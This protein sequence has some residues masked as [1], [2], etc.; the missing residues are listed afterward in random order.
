RLGGRLERD[1]APIHRRRPGSVGCRGR[2]GQTGAV[3]QGGSV[4]SRSHQSRSPV[5]RP[6]PGRRRPGESTSGGDGGGRVRIP[7]LGSDCF[8]EPIALERKAAASDVRRGALDLPEGWRGEG[9]KLRGSSGPPG[10]SDCPAGIPWTST[11]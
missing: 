4:L 5:L 6:H 3:D 2:A 10:R 1:G 9:G 11:T 7:N 8:S